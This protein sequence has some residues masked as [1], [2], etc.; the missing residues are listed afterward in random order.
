MDCIFVAFLWR[1]AEEG[2][3]TKILLE[4]VIMKKL[5]VLALVLCMASLSS[6]ALLSNYNFNELGASAD[7]LTADSGPANIPGT[8]VGFGQI[9]EDDGSLAVKS[10][11]Q[12]GGTV[13]NL[14]GP[15][16]GEYVK[17]G[18]VFTQGMGTEDRTAG[19]WFKCTAP[20]PVASMNNRW[21]GLIGA[22][23]NW[24]LLVGGWG[25]RRTRAA[26]EHG[27]AIEYPANPLDDGLWHNI[28][29]VDH[30]SAT[31][32]FQKLY[33]DGLLA[34]QIST[35]NT[36]QGDFGNVALG[37]DVPDN[38]WGERHFQ[39]QMDQ[40]F[41]A[42]NAMTQAEIQ[43]FTGIPEPATLTLLGLGLALLR[44]KNS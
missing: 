28:V 3:V 9:V 33:I 1:V 15:G 38:S 25:D 10:S 18:P 19:G 26:W 13:M 36:A 2:R 21:V 41:F 8:I 30:L 39:G 24:S 16:T 42:N 5:L 40:C 6:A 32:G 31:D 23:G 20:D 11:G 7:E 17:V 35:T 37:D 12:A 22:S 4:E 14:D 29:M 34:A 44:R 27:G 43:A